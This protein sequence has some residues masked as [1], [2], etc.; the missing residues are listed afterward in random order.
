MLVEFTSR[1]YV[2][3]KEN[4]LLGDA[5]FMYFKFDLVFAARQGSPPN[6]ARGMKPF[7]FMLMLAAAA[8]EERKRKLRA[9]AIFHT[10]LIV[11]TLRQAIRARHYFSRQDL[12]QPGSGT[13]WD[14]L[15]WNGTDEGLLSFLAFDRA[16]F[17]ELHSSFVRADPRVLHLFEMKQGGTRPRGRPCSCDSET[18]LAVGLFYVVNSCSEKV[19]AVSFSFLFS[20][21]LRLLCSP[22]LDRSFAQS[23]V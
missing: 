16:S 11:Y 17:Q 18:L 6:Q 22:N 19:L 13:P 10:F 1:R 14:F 21:T 3:V 23:L 4:R 5:D 8:E 2:F 15:R 20:Q 7:V 12:I 9:A